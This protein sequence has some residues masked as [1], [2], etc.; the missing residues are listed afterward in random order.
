MQIQWYPGHMH[1][2]RRQ[3]TESLKDIDLVIEI[4]DARI[5]L[6]SRNPVIDEL[7]KN[8]HRLLIL[9]KRDLADPGVTGQWISYFSQTKGIKSLSLSS[10]EEGNLN[11]VMRIGKN[12]CKE[13]QWFTR[14]PVYA[15]ITGIPNVGK[16]TLLNKLAGGRKAPVSNKPGVTKN[17][18]RF[19]L[20]GGFDL[21]DTPGVLWPKFEDQNVGYRLA[22]IGS[23]KDSILD[24]QDIARYTYLYLSTAY[25]E[26]IRS[27]FKIEKLPPDHTE[28]INLI[29]R[30]RGFL[31]K[32]GIVDY[33]RACRL[34]IQET[35]DGK[36]GPVSFEVPSEA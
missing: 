6:S 30:K 31:L 18:Q 23:I 14:R 32:G 10:T 20:P 11:K 34:L 2:A 26:K 16:S 8:K 19:S 7:T 12:L 28:G 5:P 4:V 35:R 15:M 1:K 36:L 25:P 21:M 24:L 33:D 22:V 13:E 17:L 9:N 29:G 27:R 3:I